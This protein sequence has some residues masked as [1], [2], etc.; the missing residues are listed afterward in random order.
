MEY[1]FITGTNRGIGL[2][3]TRQ[4]AQ[5][6]EV[7]VFAACR[8]PDEANDLQE[9]A[10]L[11]NGKITVIPLD[12]TDS[13][14]IQQAVETVRQQTD[15][16]DVL[17]NNAGIDLP[18]REQ[19]FEG[20]TPE[21][22]RSVYEINTI[23]PLMITRVFA[24]LLKKS[25]E[26]QSRQARVVNFAS[27][28]GSITQRDYGD[29][30]AYCAS[31]AAL[32][33]TTRGLAIDMRGDKVIC[34]AL[35]PGWVKTDMGGDAAPLNPEDAVTGILKVVDQLSESDSGTFLQWNGE[36]LPW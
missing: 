30:Y 25:S 35:D 14:A 23:A 26:T 1:V 2:E 28:M 27:E 34:I 8:H 33:M 16:L 4:F 36:T 29:Y 15:R 12:V 13:E 19:S 7:L 5:R 11:R 10:R 21:A 18:A 32:N 6:D 24:D 17:L 31:K 3:L 22:M 20:I 9:L